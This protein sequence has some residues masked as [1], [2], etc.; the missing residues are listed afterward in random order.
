MNGSVEP[1]HKTQVVLVPGLA[2]GGGTELRT[3][4]RCQENGTPGGS[5]LT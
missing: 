1:R 4:E 2:E 5:S 3:W